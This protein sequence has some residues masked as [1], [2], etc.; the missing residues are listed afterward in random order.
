ML[1]TNNSGESSALSSTFS[2]LL[3][4]GRKMGKVGK[5]G[6]GQ[7]NANRNQSDRRLSKIAI[8]LSRVL[9]FAFA[10]PPVAP[11]FLPAIS[12]FCSAAAVTK[13]QLKPLSMVG[14]SGAAG[15]S[16]G[17]TAGYAENW[18]QDSP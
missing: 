3:G 7:Q 12:S 14:V 9:L 17:S 1:P 13:I 18:D 8:L 16:D 11:F 2:V 5:V 6:E 10:P 4:M 15:W